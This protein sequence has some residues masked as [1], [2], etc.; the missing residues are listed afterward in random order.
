MTWCTCWRERREA[1][2]LTTL[3]QGANLAYTPNMESFKEAMRGEEGLSQT[4][5]LN[6]NKG[7]LRVRAVKITHS[8]CPN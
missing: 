8:H 2:V 3:G 5:S 4:L 6:M 7:P 1:R